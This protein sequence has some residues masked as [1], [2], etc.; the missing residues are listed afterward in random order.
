MNEMTSVTRPGC[1]AADGRHDEPLGLGLELPVHV[2]AVD[3]HL[4]DVEL[5]GVEDELGDRLDDVDGDLD[6]PLERGRVE[7]GASSTS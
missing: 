6:P 3:A 7:V 1:E 4:V 5:D 2:A